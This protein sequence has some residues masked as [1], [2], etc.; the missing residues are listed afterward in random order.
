MIRKLSIKNITISRTLDRRNVGILFREKAIVDVLKF[1][2][3]T[4]VG[5]RL[6][7]EVD[8]VNS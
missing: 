3:K 5:K 8:R 7:E 4:E 6:A 2:K 1:I